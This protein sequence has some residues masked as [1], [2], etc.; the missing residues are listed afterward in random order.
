MSDLIQRRTELSA[1]LVAFFR[2]LRK[3]GFTLGPAEQADALRAVEVLDP[4]QDPGTFR[5]ALRATL[6][7]TLRDLRRFD[8]LYDQYFRELRRAVE[9]KGKKTATPSLKPKPR[10]EPPKIPSLKDWLN[11]NRHTDEEELA[12]YSPGEVLARKDFSGI[13][14][15]EKE[16]LLRLIK[17]LARSLA[18]KQG[19]RRMRSRQGNRLDLRGTLRQNMRRGGELID[20]RWTSP[21]PR[22][23]QVILLCDVSRSM[24]LYSRFL[25]QFAYAFQQAYQRIEVFAFSTSLRR[26]SPQLKGPDFD[27]ALDELSTAVPGWSGGTRI[28]ESL[29]AFVRDYGRRLLHRQSLVILLSDGLDTGDTDLLKESMRRMHKKAGKVVWLNPLAGRQGYQPAT[30][31]MRAALPFIDVFASAHN[32]ES[33]RKLARYL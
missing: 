21:R 18:L 29:D 14:F 9:S 19:R 2:Y 24:D 4:F 20:L 3:H 1:N 15:E 11:G 10:D 13:Q 6:A 12:S 25:I 5:A 17:R 7:R 26:I 16:E 31:G 32:V 30:K 8:D 33:L 27:K 28:G 23:Q 22:R